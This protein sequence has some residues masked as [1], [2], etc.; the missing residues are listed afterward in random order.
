MTSKKDYEAIAAILA[1]FARWATIEDE[2]GGGYVR[3]D[4]LSAFVEALA[5]HY[6]S[7]KPPV[8]S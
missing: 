8:R 4:Y 7:D 6:A 3:T 5:K 2:A 1:E